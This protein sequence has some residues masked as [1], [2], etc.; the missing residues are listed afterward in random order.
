[1]PKRLTLHEFIEKSKK[2]HNNKYLYISTEYKNNITHVG[3]ECPLHGIFYQTP[4]DHIQGCGCPKCGMHVCRINR[5]IAKEKFLSLATKKYADKYDYSYSCY[6]DY[7]T[8]INIICPVHGSFSQ[9]PHL[10]LLAKYGCPECSNMIVTNKKYN[11][12]TTFIDKSRKIHGTVYDYS[13]VNYKSSLIKVIIICRNHGK[14]EV[15]PNNHIQGV[16]CKQ[17]SSNVSNKET[18]WLDSL[19]VPNEYRQKIIK[20]KNKKIK[21]D[22]YNP[23]TNTIY[24]FWGDYWH[25]NPKIYDPY[26]R[27]L[28]NKKTFGELYKETME[29]RELICGAGYNLIEIWES[30]W[31]E[32]INIQNIKDIL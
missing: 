10:H 26:N 3:I 8:P 13:L 15:T 11:D 24:E 28:N 32:M 1:M 12:V 6:V 7:E 18:A 25:G 30:D 20:I 29:K 4:K 21:P 9:K 17:C 23:G 16:G 2:I 27:N 5:K 19:K 22:A 31:K 14:F